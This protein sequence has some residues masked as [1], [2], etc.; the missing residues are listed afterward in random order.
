LNGFK[1]RI[2]EWENF[3]TLRLSEGVEL[4]VSVLFGGADVGI[5]DEQGSSLE[6]GKRQRS[7]EGIETSAH[8]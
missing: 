2:A 1:G 4:Q 5:A 8:G 7:G 3:L 6:Y